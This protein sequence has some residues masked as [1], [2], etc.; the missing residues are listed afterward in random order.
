MCEARYSSQLGTGSYEFLIDLIRG[1]IKI[2]D[3]LK[4]LGN[5]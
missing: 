1:Y 4:K 3:D 5:I 2:R